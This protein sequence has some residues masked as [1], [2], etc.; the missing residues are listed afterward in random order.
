MITEQNFKRMQEIE[1]RSTTSIK[2]IEQFLAGWVAM[3]D[4]ES[5][6]AAHVCNTLLDDLNWIQGVIR[7]EI[8]L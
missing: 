7:K 3:N 2:L 1:R 4:C 6:I 5:G 8:K